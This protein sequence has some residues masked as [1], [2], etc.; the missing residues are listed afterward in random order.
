LKIDFEST[1]DDFIDDR[2]FEV[3]RTGGDNPIVA[4]HGCVCEYFNIE[5]PSAQSTQSIFNLQ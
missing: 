1:I 2:G 5:R 4:S 3:A